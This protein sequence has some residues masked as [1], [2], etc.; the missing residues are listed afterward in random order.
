MLKFGTKK[1]LLIVDS[2]SHTPIRQGYGLTS[3][4]K[5]L[6]NLTIHQFVGG[7]VAEVVRGHV[8]PP[9]KSLDSD[10]NF[11]AKHTLFCRELRFVAI[12]A[13][14]LEIFGHKKCLFG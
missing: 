14:F 2:I 8:G 4:S 9:Q 6:G 7:R 11:K 12:Y 13:I 5:W 3:I 1:L 10:E